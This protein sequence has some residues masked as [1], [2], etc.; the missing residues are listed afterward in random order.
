MFALTVAAMVVAGITLGLLGGGGSILTVPILI[1]LAGLEA[2]EAIS[3]SLLVVAVTSLASLLP[4]ARAGRVRWRTGV[5][6]GGAGAA[7][8]Y[9]GG[10]LAGHLPG[11]V[12]LAGF[13]VMMA[14]T[15]VAMLRRRDRSNPRDDDAALTRRWPTASVAAQGTT[16][17]LVTGMVGA[18]GGFVV[19]PAL[20][21]LGG[22]TAPDAVGTSLVVIAM[23]SL[24]G[25]A[26]H[27][28]SVQLD[29]TLSLTVTGTAVAGSL[30][31]AHLTGRIDPTLLR[32]AFGWFIIAMAALILAGQTPTVVRHAL[33]DTTAATT[34]RGGSTSLNESLPDRRGAERGMSRTL[35]FKPVPESRCARG[36]RMVK[37]VPPRSGA[38]TVTVPPWAVTS[39]RTTARPMPEPFT[40]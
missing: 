31:G 38:E 5:L 20:I 13:A 24:A 40:R 9:A 1:Y 22:M 16:V 4:H 7:G 30:A 6:F 23:N 32:R 36:R 12:L 15:A 28:G 35:R 25:L 3:T 37:A 2:H 33:A 26:G 19:V 18:G 29:W 27:L 34:V 11:G 21:L 17:G 14:V 39:S 10:R 8:A